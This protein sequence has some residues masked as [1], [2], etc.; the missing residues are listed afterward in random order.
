MGGYVIWAEENSNIGAGV[1]SGSQF[2]WGNGGT[3]ANN[4]MRIPP[5]GEGTVT[6]LAMNTETAT[7]AEV[8]L[9]KNGSLTGESVALAA[10]R[11][12]T[13]EV[14]IEVAAGD[15]VSFRTI[16]GSGGGGAVVS[17]YIDQGGGKS[18]FRGR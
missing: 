1:S 13:S 6:G 7:T 5:G 17:A 4:Q 3:G 18:T 11:S 16:S 15:T 2:S 12:G 10:S 8:E 9:E 14:S